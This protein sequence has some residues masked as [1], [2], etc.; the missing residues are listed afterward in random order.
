MAAHQAPPSLGFFSLNQKNIMFYEYLD[1][2]KW[3][4]TGLLTMEDQDLTFFQ[5][6]THMYM[7]ISTRRAL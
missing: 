2:K 3:R 4:N 7:N 1:V 5:T 6:P